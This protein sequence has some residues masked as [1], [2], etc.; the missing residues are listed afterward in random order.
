MIQVVCDRCRTPLPKGETS[1]R[2]AIDLAW[3]S[4]SAGA[5]WN[6]KDSQ[7]IGGSEHAISNDLCNECAAGLVAYLAKK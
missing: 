4:A 1:A 5:N 6:T 2:I 3:P 7:M